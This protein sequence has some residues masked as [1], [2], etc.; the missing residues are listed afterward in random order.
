[1]LNIAPHK[2]AG[3]KPQLCAC[4]I[5][6]NLSPIGNPVQEAKVAHLV[7]PQTWS[8]DRLSPDV[9]DEDRS[10][11]QQRRRQSQPEE[12]TAVV[13]LERLG[14]LGP[15]GNSRGG[16]QPGMGLGRT[17]IRFRQHVVEDDNNNVA[18]QKE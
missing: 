8:V 7:R 14:N 16:G 17:H 15:G 13:V 4:G 10:V 18:V 9:S 6:L 1:M 12:T 11:R 5:D 2:N 3:D